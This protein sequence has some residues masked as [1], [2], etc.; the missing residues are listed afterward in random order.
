[1]TTAA[2]CDNLIIKCAFLLP[3]VASAEMHHIDL[4]AL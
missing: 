3:E 4:I 2:L 1:M